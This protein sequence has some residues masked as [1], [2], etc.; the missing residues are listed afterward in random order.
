MPI[1]A[2]DADPAG[3]VAPAFGQLAREDGDEDD[4][5][6]AEDDLERRQRQQGDPGLWVGEDLHVASI[7]YYSASVGVGRVMP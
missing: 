1:A 3:E 5:V 7:G 2:D 4:V 6:D